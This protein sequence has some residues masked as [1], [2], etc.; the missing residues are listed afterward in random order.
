M[1]DTGTA[2]DVT[3]PDVAVLRERR[4]LAIVAHGGAAWATA[5]PGT[6]S[7]H[8]SMHRIELEPG[9]QTLALAHESEAVYFVVDG[10]GA[11][12]DLHIGRAQ[13][14]R[15]HTML[16]V[17]RRS[18]YRIRATTPL[19]VVG[20]PCPPDPALYGTRSLREP[21][22]GEGDGPVELYDADTEGVPV[23]M[24]GKQVRLVVW[25]G[26]GAEIATMNFAIL[27]PGEQNQP[28]THLASD[29][30]IA[31]LEGEGTIDDL[32]NGT[33]HAFAAGDVVFVRTGIQHMVKA[34]RGAQI[35]SAGGP[36]PPDFGMLEALGLV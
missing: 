8:R 3:P 23:A 2:F 31:I 14:L 22:P 29:D 34:N 4:A 6:G 10:E 32:T 25:P 24:I 18:G 36:C 33:T 12:D 5:W 16:Y 11:V 20:G 13:P 27:E 26:T 28:H 30:T 19:V 7:H 21:A 1:S 35:V 17:P 9:G 15:A